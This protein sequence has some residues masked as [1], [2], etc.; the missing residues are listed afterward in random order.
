VSQNL[1][2]HEYQSK[3]LFAAYGIPTPRG[4]VVTTPAE[5]TAAARELGGNVVIKSQILAGGRGKAGG[6]RLAESADEVDTIASQLLDHRLLTH[7][8]GSS[9]SQIRRLLI[10]EKLQVQRE[11][12]LAI[13]IDTSIALPVAL[14]RSK[15][16][17]DIEELATQNPASIVSADIDPIAG[18]RSYQVRQLISALDLSGEAVKQATTLLQNLY[19][20]LIKNDCSLAEINPLAVTID[21]RLVALDAKIVLDDSALFRHPH[22]AELRD[23]EDADP[24]ENLAQDKGINNYVRL[25]GNIGCIVNGAGLAMATMDIIKEVGGEPANF[26]DVGGGNNRERIFGAL[27]IMAEDRRVQAV[28]VN[29]FG[30]ITRADLVA[31]AI[32]EG[33]AELKLDVSIVARLAGAGAD[34]A[35]A[36]IKSS[37]TGIISVTSLLEAA[38][39]AVEVAQGS[40]G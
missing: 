39:T 37:Q 36:I 30:G 7:Q 27:E 6:I 18:L 38:Q 32:V 29:I 34:E 15:G 2:L 1:R 24:L 28:L 13:L 4:K 40:T 33:V 31:Q 21:E 12:F 11:L 17:I 25:E 14:A 16:G 10:E 23:R 20:L 26:L 3:S 19:E 35:N 22:L 9:S 5:A 8:S